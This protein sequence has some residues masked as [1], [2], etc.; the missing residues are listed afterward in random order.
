MA[1]RERTDID[2]FEFDFFD[3]SPTTE[4]TRETQGPPR[5]RPRLP[6]RPP[7]GGTPVLRQAALIVGAIFLVVV[8][9]IWVNSCRADA[10]TGKYEDYM[11]AVERIGGQSAEVGEEL[12]NLIFSSGIQIEDLQNQLVGLRD[13]QSQSVR[14]AQGLDVPGPLRE[15]HEEFVEALEFRVSGLNGLATGLSQV[16]G[17]EA[18]G[19]GA[20]PD[21]EAATGDQ[22]ATE[23]PAAASADATTVGTLLASQANRLVASDVIYA[24]SFATPAGDVMESQDV[25]GIGVPESR[26]VTNQELASPASWK[27]IVERLTRPPAAGGLHGNRIGAVRALP[28]GDELSRTD[29][30][31]VQASDRLAFEVLVENSGD[32]QETQVKVNLTIQQSPEPIREEATIDAINPGDTKSVVFRNLDQVSFGPRTILKVTVEPV[33]GEENTNNN[34]AEYVVIF[35]FG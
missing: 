27:L 23:D 14:A 35:T 19:A 9:V 20:P 4:V 7:T 30:N 12:N 32:S 16:T 3:D 21:D 6:T 31:T 17:L 26:F 13:R 34:T 1:E 18:E 2:S 22:A 33:P 11:Q 5:R 8:L 28:A 25:T 15:Q 10:K 29:E 24:D